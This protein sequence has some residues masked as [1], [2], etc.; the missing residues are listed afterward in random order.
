VV[1]NYQTTNHVPEALSRLTEIY[2]LLGMKDEARRTASVLGYNYPGNSW[3]QTSYNDLFDNGLVP[4][5]RN[6][7]SSKTD[8]QENFLSRAWHSIF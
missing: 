2:L 1:D 8:G 5:A 4:N 6:E 3:Y 7:P